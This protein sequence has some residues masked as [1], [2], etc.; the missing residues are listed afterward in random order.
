MIL[1][2][3]LTIVLLVLAGIALFAVTA[4]GATFIVVLGD[5]IVCGVLI[6]GIIRLMIKKRKK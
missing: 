5:L 4:G 6:I 3:V 2:T 1:F